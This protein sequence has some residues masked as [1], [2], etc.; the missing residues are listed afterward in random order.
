MPTAK[1][2]QKVGL[3]NGF[4]EIISLF[5]TVQYFAAGPRQHRKSLFRQIFIR[6]KPLNVLK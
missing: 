5:S 1:G 3:R 6:S 2:D 4:L